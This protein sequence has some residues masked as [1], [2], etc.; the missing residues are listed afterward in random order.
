[1]L[2]DCNEQ[3]GRFPGAGCQGS[4]SRFHIMSWDVFLMTNPVLMNG[5]LKGNARTCG[6]GSIRI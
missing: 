5:A 3:W 2:L 4:R 1:M 6:Q